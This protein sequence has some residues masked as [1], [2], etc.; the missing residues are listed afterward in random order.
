MDEDTVTFENEK[1]VRF[2]RYGILGMAI[3][4][5]LG[6]LYSMIVIPKWSLFTIT[7]MSVAVIF[8]SSVPF[9]AVWKIEY[10]RRPYRI[11]IG[12]EGLILHR[13]YHSKPYVVPW[14]EVIC[15]YSASSDPSIS[16]GRIVRDG[17][18]AIR[19]ESKKYGRQLLTLNTNIADAAREKYREVIGTFPP[20]R[21]ET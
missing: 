7:I 20:L 1:D 13:H 11:D 6:I 14:K 3:L 4:L 15:I 18:F 21:L 17:Y 12:S 10:L 8:G 16:K 9:L 19:D 5:P 2:L